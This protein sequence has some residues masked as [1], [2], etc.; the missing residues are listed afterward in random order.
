MKDYKDKVVIVTGAAS[1]IG[2]ATAIAFAKEGAKVA[3]SDIQEQEAIETIKI[4]EKQN[5]T[6]IF[7]GCD[8]SDE[9]SVKA[10]VKRVVD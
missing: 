8:V 2:R 9:N 3:V 4:I 5:G 6:A 7:V 1:G 10:M